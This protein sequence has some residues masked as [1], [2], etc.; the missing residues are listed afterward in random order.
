MYETRLTP[1]NKR[2]CIRTNGIVPFFFFPAINDFTE[3]H[4]LF[5]N[6]TPVFSI[7]PNHSSMSVI[8]AT[9]SVFLWI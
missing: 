5:I 9:F 4:C 1:M 7:F 8:H 6:N 2:D 3:V